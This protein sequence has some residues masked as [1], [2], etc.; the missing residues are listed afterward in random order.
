[1]TS[2]PSEIQLATVLI[3]MAQRGLIINASDYTWQG[4]ARQYLAHYL[5]PFAITLEQRD[6]AQRQY[7]TLQE[8]IDVAYGRAVEA[9]GL[10]SLSAQTLRPFVSD[11]QKLAIAMLF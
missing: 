1:M 11:A 3:R 7:S 8:S 10:T 5:H 9:Y 4:V 6:A 2:D